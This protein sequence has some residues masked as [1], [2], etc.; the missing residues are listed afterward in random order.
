M[1]KVFYKAGYNKRKTNCLSLKNK[2]TQSGEIA[3]RASTPVAQS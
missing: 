3:Q 1:Y 2:N